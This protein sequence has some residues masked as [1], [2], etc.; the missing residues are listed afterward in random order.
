MQATEMNAK[1]MIDVRLELARFL[2]QQFGEQTMSQNRFGRGFSR[3]MML[4]G[5]DSSWDDGSEENKKTRISPA[6]HMQSTH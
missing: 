4:E 5:G 1:Y 3:G 2:Q 6:D